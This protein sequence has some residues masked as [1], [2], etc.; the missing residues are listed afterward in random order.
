MPERDWHASLPGVIVTAA[1]LIGDG[2]GQVLVVKP[3]YRDH[4]TLPGGVCEFGEEPR[5][6]C[7]REVAE[8]IGLALPV[9][10]LLAVD[11]RLPPELYGPQA[12][13]SVHFIFDCGLLPSLSAVRLQAEELDD[14]TFAAATE[15][16]SLLPAQALP[17]V[18]AAIAALPS[19]CARYVPGAVGG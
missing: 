6:G 11:W 12:R 8:E 7:A 13:P 16:S 17:R 10:R 2:D 5:A 9:G 15:L 3:N 1:G 14:C 4:W 18:L 19:G